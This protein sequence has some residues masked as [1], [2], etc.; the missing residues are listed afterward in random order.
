MGRKGEIGLRIEK[1]VRNS[2][3]LM[4]NIPN[5]CNFSLSSFFLRSTLFASILISSSEPESYARSSMIIVDVSG[6]GSR[7]G[8]GAA[9]VVSPDTDDDKLTDVRVGV[10]PAF[11]SLLLI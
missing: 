11:A 6:E 10:A 9:A 3:N 5:F 2:E 4:L 1:I 8:R 7:D